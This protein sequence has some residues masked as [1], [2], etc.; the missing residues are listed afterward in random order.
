MR[1]PGRSPT[2]QYSVSR[3]F[4]TSGA[5]LD[6]FGVF[7][8]IFFRFGHVQSMYGSSALRSTLGHGVVT[9]ARTYISLG[10]GFSCVSI[11]KNTQ[12]TTQYIRC[13]PNVL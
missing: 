7:K 2:T 10:K 1:K 8:K 13:S 6:F 9:Q 11:P 3:P 5:S 4:L 12:Y